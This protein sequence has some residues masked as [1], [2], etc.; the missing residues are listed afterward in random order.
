MSLIHPSSSEA[1]DS[2][3]YLFSVP[4]TQTTVEDGQDVEI[5]PLAALAPEAPI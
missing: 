1:L 5:H 4:P 3:I 2:G